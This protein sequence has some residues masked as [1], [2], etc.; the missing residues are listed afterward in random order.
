M[1]RPAGTVAEV[2]LETQQLMV[3][4]RRNEQNPTAA[5]DTDVVERDFKRLG[6]LG[7]LMQGVNQRLLLLGRI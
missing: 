6:C 3:G 4:I 2:F 7:N 1:R 5:E